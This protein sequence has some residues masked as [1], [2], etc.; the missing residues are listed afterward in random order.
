MH[1]R[2]FVQAQVLLANDRASFERN[3]MNL[4]NIIEELRAVGRL[5]GQRMTLS[6][7]SPGSLSEIVT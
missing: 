1:K 7:F 2:L 5:N 4:K 6:L 3:V